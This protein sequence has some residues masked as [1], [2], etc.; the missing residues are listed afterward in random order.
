MK[1]AA[2]L[3]T[4]VLTDIGEY[5][6]QEISPVEAGEILKRGGWLSAV[7]HAATAQ[8]MTVDLGSIVPMNRVEYRQKIG[9]TALVFM[10]LQRP[11]EGVILTTQEIKKLK[12][13][14]VT[15]TRTG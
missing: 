5:R 8:V 11:E 13:R 14:Y 6:C 15:L 4:P 2:I 12:Y 7:G 9:E 3:S 1:F 10:L